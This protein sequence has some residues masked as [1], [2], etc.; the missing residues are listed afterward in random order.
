MDALDAILTRRTVPPA[1]MGP[2]GPGEAD[3]RRILAAGV[4]APDHGLLRPWRFLV[5]R[6]A[7]RERLGE[8]FAD[9]GREI[10]TLV[11]QEATL[12][13][14]ELSQKAARVGKDVGMLAVGG[15]VAYTGLLV[16]VACVVILLAQAGLGWWGS[17]LLVGGVMLEAMF[18]ASLWLT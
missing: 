5:V 9:L 1:K 6:G 17:T 14:A 13:K 10:S 12:A 7:G 4:A 2:P 15:M 16:L 18:G 3:L 8:L 11:R